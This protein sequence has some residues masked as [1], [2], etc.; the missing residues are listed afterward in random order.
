METENVLLAVLGGLVAFAGVTALALCFITVPPVTRDA[1]VRV[2][3]KNGGVGSGVHI[4][5]GLVITAAHVVDKAENIQIDR[6][7]AEVLWANAGYDLAAVRTETNGPAAQLRCTEPEIGEQ[8][9]AYGHPAGLS[10]TRTQGHVAGK[11]GVVERWR[12][13]FA[14]DLT[15]FFGNS[16]GPAF[17]SHGQVAAIVVGILQGSGFS[18]LVP[19]SEVCRML[20][21]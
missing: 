5:H 2:D 10:R 19:G 12:A 20:G 18:F 14:A 11:T 4:G 17:D 16:G 8:L 1:V 6:K 15:V 3:M 21:R 7:P 13:V 9:T